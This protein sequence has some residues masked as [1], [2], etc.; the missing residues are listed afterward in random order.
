MNKFR[1]LVVPVPRRSNRVST[2]ELLGLL[3]QHSSI[4]VRERKWAFFRGTKEGRAL[5]S[6]TGP[7]YLYRG[8]AARHVPCFPTIYRHYRYPVRFL[9]QLCADDAAEI[10]AGLAK[11]IMYFSEL[12]RHPIVKWAKAERLEL[13]LLEV[14]QHYGV[15]TPLID[16]SESIE[17]A[18]FFA[19]HDYAEDRRVVPRTAG[20][21][22]LYIVDREKVPEAYAKRIKSIAIQPF[23]RPFQQWAWSCELL[24]GGVFRAMPLS[25]YSR[26]RTQ[27]STGPRS[28]GTRGSTW[29]SV[30]ARSPS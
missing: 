14:A 23:A 29:E 15:A 25:C 10:V 7:H 30:S 11:T 22:V 17:V 24:M 26:I 20:S 6:T 13:D 19:T 28:A 21:G 12:Q 2:D 1:P 8:Q 9:D 4:G 5:L 16:L 3:R 27:R 18:L